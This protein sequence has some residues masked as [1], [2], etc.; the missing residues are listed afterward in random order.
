ML[1]EKLQALI[2]VIPPG[3]E[4]IVYVVSC[5]ILLYIIDCFCSLLKIAFR[6]LK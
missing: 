5:L 1:L 6:G 3:S 4:D 2:G